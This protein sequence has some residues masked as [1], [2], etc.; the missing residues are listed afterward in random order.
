MKDVRSTATE[1]ELVRWT[2]TGLVRSSI[3]LHLT[4]LLV[5]IANPLWWRWLL[6]TVLV[7]HLLLGGIGMWPR[8][9][10]L[11]S[12]L[13]RLPQASRDSG[14]VA[15]TFDDGPDPNVTPLV[16]DLLDR[17]SA[18]ASFFCIGQYARAYPQIVQ[19]IVN[20]G[21][22]VENHSDRH[23][24][25]FACYLPHRLKREIDD[26][27]TALMS[28]TGHAPQ[29]FRAPMGLRNPF[30]DPVLVHSALTYVSWTRR[31][32]DCVSTSPQRV[33]RRLTR[34]LSAGDVILMHDGSSARRRHDDPIVLTVLPALLDYLSNRG[35][36][37]VSLPIAFAGK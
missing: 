30:L 8:S 25:C 17:H 12:N 33:M 18:K 35:L 3:W 28:I 24:Y 10:L 34:G 11:G 1:A 19:E 26:A 13:V 27:Q 14:Y 4:V 22:S 37:P 21:H 29:F 2:P 15:L 20:R 16:L 32:W 7:N 23:P 31:G 6:A 9:R 36:K 5:L